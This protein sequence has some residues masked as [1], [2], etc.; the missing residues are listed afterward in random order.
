MN[1]RAL[2]GAQTCNPSSRAA[3]VLCLKPHGHWDG[4]HSYYFSFVME[5]IRIILMYIL[6]SLIRCQ[7]GG[8]T[9]RDD[10]GHITGCYSS[11]WTVSVAWCDQ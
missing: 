11:E 7:L 9:R 2:S 6:C 8:T 1:I 3:V 10:G 4:P 5:E